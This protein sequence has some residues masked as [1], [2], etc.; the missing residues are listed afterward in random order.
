MTWNQTKKSTKPCKTDRPT[1][2]FIAKVTFESTKLWKADQWVAVTSDTGKFYLESD[3]QKKN[4]QC[5]LYI[6]QSQNWKQDFSTDYNLGDNEIYTAQMPH[7]QSA[8]LS[9]GQPKHK[10]NM[11]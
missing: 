8:L 7:Q 1:A 11:V 6:Y 3:F 5:P 4:F 9:V 10:C 2:G